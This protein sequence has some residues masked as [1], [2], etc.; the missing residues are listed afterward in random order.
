[1]SGGSLISNARWN[2]INRR[3]WIHPLPHRNMLHCSRM[4]TPLGQRGWNL[5][6][7]KMELYLGSRLWAAIS[8]GP[9]VNIS[10]R[11]YFATVTLLSLPFVFYL[12]CSYLVSCLKSRIVLGKTYMTLSVGKLISCPSISY[13]V[14]KILTWRKHLRY[15]KSNFFFFLMQLFSK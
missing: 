10:C 3:H 6:K 4:G 2:C 14:L 13:P 5:F 11:G 8:P 7:Q 15:C 9:L 12:C 1:M